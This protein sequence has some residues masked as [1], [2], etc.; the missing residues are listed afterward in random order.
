MNVD[1]LSERAGCPE[2]QLHHLH[3]SVFDVKCT[4]CS[5][6]ASGAP[7]EHVLLMKL[8]CSTREKENLQ[9][10]DTKRHPLF[11]SG[12][13]IP[14][15]P[16]SDCDG[17]IRLAIVW[18]TES[19]PQPLLASIHQWICPSDQSMTIDTMLVIGT[20]ALVYPA[21]AYI[22]AARRKGARVVV[23]HIEKEDP[24]LLGLEEQDWY[25]QGDAVV[26]M[27][28]MLRPVIGS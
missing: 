17:L 11:I 1:D 13:D 5:F 20:S 7:A 18:F 23:V 22:E 2:H 28:E 14:R 26:L 16:T 8:L 10:R 3:G 25:F 6:Q 4:K 24:S 21:T 15:C 12:E 27:P 19:I 9:N